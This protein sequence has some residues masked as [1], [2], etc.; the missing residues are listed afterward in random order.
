MK[1]PEP[2]LFDQPVN[3]GLV[4]ER[5][6][7]QIANVIGYDFGIARASAAMER[8]IAR[9]AAA[10]RREARCPWPTDQIEFELALI[11]S[12]IQRGKRGRHER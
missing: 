9:K 6:G 10:A 1:T 7:V 4:F 12:S 8:K 3:S 11:R 2:T 5:H